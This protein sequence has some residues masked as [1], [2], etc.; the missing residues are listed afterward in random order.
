MWKKASIAI[1][2]SLTFSPSAALTAEPQFDPFAGI[3]QG[4]AQGMAVGTDFSAESSYDGGVSG[5]RSRQGG[6][7]IIG[8]PISEHKQNITVDGAADLTINGGTAN[9]GLNVDQHD[10]GEVPVLIMQGAAISQGVVIASSS[11]EGSVQ[12]VNL[13]TR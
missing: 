7:V 5:D 6:N 3:V 10:D 8:S 9:Q 11:S 4:I 12:G 1:V 13:V 2:L